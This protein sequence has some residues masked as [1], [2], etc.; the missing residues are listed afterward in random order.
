MTGKSSVCESQNPPT[1]SAAHQL[2]VSFSAAVDLTL[3]SWTGH[4]EAPSNGVSFG[5]LLPPIGKIGDS[6]VKGAQKNQKLDFW[7]TKT[8]MLVWRGSKCENKNH[9]EEEALAA[10]MFAVSGQMPKSKIFS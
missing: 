9:E 3:Q 7:E 2:M 1:H 6:F 8:N 10:G 5:M 4:G